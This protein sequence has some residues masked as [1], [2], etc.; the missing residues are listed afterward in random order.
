MHGNK[1]SLLF[2]T[3]MKGVGWRE[4]D[5]KDI[6]YFFKKETYVNYLFQCRYININHDSYFAM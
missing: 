3:L 6:T 2:F 1:N 5:I 4:N